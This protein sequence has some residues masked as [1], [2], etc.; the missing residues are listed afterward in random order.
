MTRIAFLTLSGL[1]EK[2]A[3]LFSASA[4]GKTDFAFR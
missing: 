3:P 2:K 4:N 1:A